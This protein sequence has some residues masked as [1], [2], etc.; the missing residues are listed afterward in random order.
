MSNKY[1]DLVK[2]IKQSRENIRPA[3]QGSIFERE[4]VRTSAITGEEE[5]AKALEEIKQRPQVRITDLQQ[6]KRVV[7]DGEVK[8][9]DAGDEDEVKEDVMS[10]EELQR[11]IE[12]TTADLSKVKPKNSR[13][14]LVNKGVGQQYFDILK[15]PKGKQRVIVF[16]KKSKKGVPP[17]IER[18]EVD[19]DIPL[20]KGRL[21]LDVGKRELDKFTSLL[22]K[23]KAKETLNRKITDFYEPIEGKGF[24]DPRVLIGAYLAKNNN[25]QLENLVLNKFLNM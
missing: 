13:K 12:E 14:A 18:D 25:K 17:S 15:D 11:L 1:A 3:L 22:R 16:T 20:I 6:K 2:I 5:R 23:G 10:E 4:M 24:Y 8:G 7:D 21:P 9:V 19:F